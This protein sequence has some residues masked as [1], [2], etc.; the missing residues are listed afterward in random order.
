M[1]VIHL[2]HSLDKIS[3]GIYNA[4]VFGSQFLFSKH[5]IS[6][7]AFVC[8]PQ[9]MAV[10]LPGVSIVYLGSNALDNT[11]VDNALSS[12]NISATDT[13]VVSHGCWLAPTRLGAM[14]AKKGFK[15]LYVPHGMLEPWSMQQGALKKKIY[16]ALFEKR[17]ANHSKKIRAVSSVEQRNL[18]QRFGR[19]IDLVEN[20]V[21]VRP[22]PSKSS[23]DVLIFLFLG[24]LHHKKGIVP[25]VEGWRS[26]FGTDN[27]RKLI[28][29]GPDQGELEKIK[30]YLGNNIEYAGAVYGDTKDAL[31]N[32]AHYF[33]LPSFSEGFPVSVLEAMSFGLIPLISSGCNF[34]QVFKEQLGFRMEPNI[35]SVET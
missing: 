27:N 24:R 16:Y 14:L 10:G 32:K 2:I 28:I 23:G 26:A 20:G 19:T 17:F 7:Y 30:P 15:W 5:N 1:K 4:A 3:F 34:D 18:A 6:T 8:S 25:L 13:V 12:N 9:S 22:Y 33:L 31:F 35:T 29:A 21:T 11:V